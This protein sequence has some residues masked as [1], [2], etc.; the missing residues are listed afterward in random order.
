MIIERSGEKIY[1][2]NPKSYKARVKK[3]LCTSLTNKAKV[4]LQAFYCDKREGY[5]EKFPL[6]KKLV[7]K[8]YQ[9][10]TST[11]PRYERGTCQNISSKEELLKYPFLLI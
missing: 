11:L 2:N 1:P 6:S 4:N 5:A 9:N 7:N 3:I 8:I 10:S